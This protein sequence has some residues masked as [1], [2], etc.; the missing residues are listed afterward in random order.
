MKNAA[1]PLS[2]E[3]ERTLAIAWRDKRDVKA[4]DRIV[5]SNLRFAARQIMGRKRLGEIEDV[6]QE[7]M[8]GMLEAAENFDPDRNVRFITYAVHFIRNAIERAEIGSRL[9]RLP[10]SAFQAVGKNRHGQE[11]TRLSEES[12]QAA[13]EAS[14]MMAS[15]DGA[16]KRTGMNVGEHAECRRASISETVA[17]PDDTSADDVVRILGSMTPLERYVTQAHVFDELTLA[18][19]GDELGLNRESVRRI[20]EGAIV[21]VKS[22]IKPDVPVSSKAYWELEGDDFDMRG[23]IEQAAVIK[24]ARG[25]YKDRFKLRARNLMAWMVLQGRSYWL[26][27]DMFVGRKERQWTIKRLRGL[28]NE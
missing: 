17:A 24:W 4:R 21:R 6:E 12:T 2:A 7:V 20:K 1:P 11:S 25:R 22:E 16:V 27:G 8:L 14:R 9:I 15:F 5:M 10:P 3:E 26:S 19:I 28:V 18:E 23:Y 13:L